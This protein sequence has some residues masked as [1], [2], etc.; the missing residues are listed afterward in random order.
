[1]DIEFHYYITYLTATRAGLTTSDAE[2]LAYSS[3]YVDENTRYLDIDQNKSTAYQNYITQTMNILKPTDVLMRI[4]P[5]F[6]FIPGDPLS[7]TA[8]RKDGKLHQ[9]NTTP[10][11]ENAN[12]IFD[13]AIESGDLY[14]IGIAAHSYVDT[15]AHQNFVGYYD[16]FNGMSGLLSRALPN[17]GHAD[18]KHKPDWPAL[19]WQDCRL[20]Q[21]TVDNKQRFLEAAVHLFR[22]LR[23]YADPG[24]SHA[25][26]VQD[27]EQLMADLTNAIGDID[28]TNQYQ[29]VRIQRYCRLSEQVNYGGRRLPLFDSRLWFRQAIDHQVRGISDDVTLLSKINPWKDKYRWRDGYKNSHWYKFQESAKAQQKSAWEILKERSFRGLALMNL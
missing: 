11:S 7:P 13:A 17:I 29:S 19:I 24:C 28:Q 10:N 23:R 18:A 9:L 4:Y 1:M 14:R 6:H 3:Q 21:A 8:Q 12:L 15:W 20:T 22:K 2:T 5:I 16:A 27:E 26:M 25:Q